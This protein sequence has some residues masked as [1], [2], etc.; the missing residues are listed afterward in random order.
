MVYF[1][2]ETATT[3]RGVA[4]RMEAGEI[5]LKRW[6][7][8]WID[9]IALSLLFFLPMIPFAMFDA[10]TGDQTSPVLG[11]VGLIGGL[12]LLAYFPVTEGIW[13]QSLGKLVTGLVVVDEKGRKP[14]VV[15]ALLR[16]LTRVVE[17]NPFLAGGVP[18][19]IV[20]AI[21]KERRRL[22]DMLAGTWVIHKKDLE[23]IRRSI[24]EGQ[25]TIFD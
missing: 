4:L 16:T 5:L 12:A 8:C 11:V 17:V 22:G 13:G 14:G 15:R 21:S 3:V 2:N 1:G 10:A 6:L 19:G 24:D 9:M 18:A 23:R 7:G 25:A 20:V